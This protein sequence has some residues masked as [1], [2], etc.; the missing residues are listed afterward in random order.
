M[1]YSSE[2]MNDKKVKQPYCWYGGSLVIW[3][4]D[5]TNCNIPLNWSLIEIKVLTL[6]KAKRGE[7]AIEEKFE[8]SRD[9]SMRF[10]EEAISVT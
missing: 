2:H 7:E 5:Q 6:L 10:E 8:A 1:C 4:E 3:I 9:W